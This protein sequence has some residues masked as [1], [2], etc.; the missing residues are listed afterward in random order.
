MTNFLINSSDTNNVGSEDFD[1]FQVNTAKDVTIKGAGAGDVISAN[2][3]VNGSD[4]LIQGGQGDDSIYF[5]AN[6]LTLN[7][8]SIR[9]GAGADIFAFDGGSANGSSR[10][11]GGG[12][13]DT[14]QLSAALVTGVV[15]GMGKGDDYITASSVASRS[16][17]V[18]LGGGADT[19][20]LVS[21]SAEATTINGGGGADLISASIVTASALMIY[22][23]TVSS[24]HYGNDTINL[25]GTLFGVS[26]IVAGGGGADSITFATALA[27]MTGSTI[28]GNGG[29][30]IITIGESDSAMGASVDGGAGADTILFTASDFDTGFGTING[31]GGADL[32]S[33][34]AGDTGDGSVILIGGAGGDSINLGDTKTADD[35]SVVIRY[36]GFSESNLSD[37]DV[38][39]ATNASGS[40]YTINQS[41][42]SAEVATSYN[43]GDFSTDTGGLVTFASAKADGVTARAEQMDAALQEGKVV[44]FADQSGVDYIFI[45]GGSKGGGTSDDFIAQINTATL[46]G[47]GLVIVGGTAISVNLA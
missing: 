23:D 14:L 4:L 47:S 39:S 44:A 42:V 12:G 6:A 35:S 22:G 7:E 24:E 17:Q 32:I 27:A 30:D 29:K 5:T 28:A 45:Q 34:S 3:A 40:V 16:S 43:D 13:N 46:A 11:A 10:I 38:I 20:H 19:L 18:L 33:V 41:A 31:G 36:S 1:L 15:F 25:S 9:G 26:G 37:M 8:A 2:A 21:A